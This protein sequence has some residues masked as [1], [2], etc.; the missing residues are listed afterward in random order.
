M[1]CKSVYLFLNKMNHSEKLEL[2]KKQEEILKSY[3]KNLENQK[4]R[5]EIEETE[6]TNCLKYVIIY[7]PTF[8]TF[9]ILNMES[10]LNV[11]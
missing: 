1:R 4:Q 8:P 3:I 9:A 11:K 6:L 7:L 10:F 2:L 5:L